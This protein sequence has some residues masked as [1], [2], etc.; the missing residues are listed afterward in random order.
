MSIFKKNETSSGYH[1]YLKK[2]MQFRLCAKYFGLSLS[3]NQV[4]N[5]IMATKKIT[6]ETGVGNISML[7]V[8]SYTRP[9]LAHSLE[10][11]RNIL[12]DSWCYSVAFDGS[13]Y[14]HSSYFDI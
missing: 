6:N 10:T 14:G 3:F 1:V 12:M 7:K 5:V 4:V 13:T 2:W 11:I 8:C 9:L